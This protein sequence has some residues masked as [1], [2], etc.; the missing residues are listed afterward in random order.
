MGKEEERST[1]CS[2]ISAALPV[3]RGFVAPP[4]SGAASARGLFAS[5]RG[6]L[7]ALRWRHGAALLGRSVVAAAPTAGPPASRN[8]RAH[9]AALAPTSCSATAPRHET[10]RQPVL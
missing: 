9:R 1:H 3:S 10:V 5:D 2:T 6:A 4:P 7:S 8:G